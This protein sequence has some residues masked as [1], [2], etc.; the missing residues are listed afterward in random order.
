MAVLAGEGCEGAYQ[1]AALDAVR[2]KV[3]LWP[4][5]PQAQSLGA[6]PAFAKACGR[7]PLLA[8]D[9]GKE[10]TRASDQPTWVCNQ[11]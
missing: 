1:L 8:L 11:Q 10:Q 4:S 2:G 7:A 5:A 3:G 9:L 6:C